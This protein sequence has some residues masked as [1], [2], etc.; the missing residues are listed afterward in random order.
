M[1]CFKN[2]DYYNMIT[3]ML[4]RYIRDVGTTINVYH[5]RSTTLSAFCFL[6]LTDV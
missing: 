1:M 4:Y 3:L 2:T 6:S 5:L